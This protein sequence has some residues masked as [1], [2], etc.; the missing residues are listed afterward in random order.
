MEAGEHTL[1]VTVTDG[2][3]TSRSRTTTFETARF[4]KAFVPPSDVVELGWS[5]IRGLGDQMYVYD[6]VVDGVSYNITLQW[7]TVSQSFKI[8]SIEAK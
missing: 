3:G 8:N 5:I 7:D 6:A 2:F 1:T 4:E